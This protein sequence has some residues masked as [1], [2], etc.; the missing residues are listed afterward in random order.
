MCGV[1]RAGGIVIDVICVVQPADVTVVCCCVT[2]GCRKDEEA[3]EDENVDK[4]HCVCDV[5]EDAPCMAC[6]ET[7]RLCGLHD[8]LFCSTCMK[9][10][11]AACVGGVI[12]EGAGGKAIT[13]P[14]QPP[15]V[16]PLQSQ[17]RM[18]G[19]Q[20]LRPLSNSCW[21]G[22]RRVPAPWG[23]GRPM[24]TSVVEMR[25]RNLGRGRRRG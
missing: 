11:H 23:K 5:R 25:H 7:G 15:L 12:S 24:S 3:A 9:W 8:G 19:A 14:Y 6:E 10:Y 13:F 22:R 4:R 16:V 1:V 21:F 18:V 17:S 20:R 2:T